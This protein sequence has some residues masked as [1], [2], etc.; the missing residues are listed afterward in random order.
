M[1][2]FRNAYEKAKADLYLSH[3]SYPKRPIHDMIE[4]AE[5]RMDIGRLKN[6]FER[7][8]FTTMENTKV[9]IPKNLHK[10]VDNKGIRL[11]ESLP[12]EAHILS[13][14]WINQIGWRFEEKLPK[15]VYGNRMKRIHSR[16]NNDAS[17]AALGAHQK[18]RG[19]WASDAMDKLEGRKTLLISDFKNFF[20]RID[21]SFML[22]KDFLESIGVEIPEHDWVL[23][24]R[25]ISMLQGWAKIDLNPGMLSHGLPVGLPASCLISNIALLPFDK[26]ML[27][28]ESVSHY[29]RYIDDIV[30]IVHG[31]KDVESVEFCSEKRSIFC[32]KEGF[33][34]R[35][36]TFIFNEEKQVVL[37]DCFGIGSKSDEKAKE[38][39]HVGN[40]DYDGC[41]FC[42][43]EAVETIVESAVSFGD[44]I[45]KP[46]TD[47][48]KIQRKSSY[49]CM[50]ALD[51]I[52]LA[53]NDENL[54]LF[55]AW[56]KASDIMDCCAIHS[57]W[58]IAH[59]YISYI[60]GKCLSSYSSANLA[61]NFENV[62]LDMLE[63]SIRSLKDPSDGQSEVFDTLMAC[64]PRE[65]MESLNGF[66][67]A[68]REDR[69]NGVK[70]MAQPC[71]SDRVAIA[72]YI[73][74]LRRA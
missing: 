52:S 5:I 22:D 27:E 37:N 44:S 20:G 64:I 72:T 25:M 56:K 15:Q 60:K 14:M 47:E 54:K 12:I 57:Q 39:L 28:D 23:H 3:D 62:A 36:G 38:A 4:E 11:V 58:D 33:I 7:Y 45:F 21:A 9:Y 65:R 29:G 24:N 53:N 42:Q 71:T 66:G 2:D 6:D 51:Y 49:S 18:A 16:R 46:K 32:C 63:H 26:M 17:A 35:A 1:R 13:A 61:N 59:D 50:I 48:E 68:S 40:V 31:D 73:A 70:E 67:K 8:D 34:S 55:Y 43:S 74:S 19:K 69:L 10:G 30:I 41:G